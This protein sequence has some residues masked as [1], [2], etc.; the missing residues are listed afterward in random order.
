MVKK[1]GF[2]VW[3]PKFQLGFQNLLND[4]GLANKDHCV[5]VFSSAKKK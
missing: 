2:G 1:V 4:F 3:L 5:S